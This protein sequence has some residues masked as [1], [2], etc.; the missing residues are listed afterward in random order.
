[1][2]TNPI[3]PKKGICDPH[4]HIFGGKAYLY[5][6]SDRSI[7]NTTW[8]MD[9]WVIWSSEDL[10]HWEFESSFKPEDSYIG[11]CDACWAVD[12]AE[13]NGKY[14]YYFSNKNIDTGVAVSENPGG[15]FRDALGK[16][17][18]PQDLTPSC[19]YDP[20]VFTDD[21]G[22]SYIIWGLPDGDGYYIAK[23]N[24]DM[25]SLAEEPKRILLDGGTARDDK[26]FVH[27]KNGKYYLSWASK[28]A[29][30]ESVYGPY[31]TMGNLRLSD[32]H[33]SFFSFKG[34]DFNAFTIFEPTKYFRSTGLC[35]VHYRKN[36]EMEADPLIAE[37]GV[38]HYDANW[39]NLQAVWFM[40][41]ENAEKTENIWGGF[42]VC[43]IS[44]KTRLYYPNIENIA[45]KKRL[46]FEAASLNETDS[47][48]EV[49]DR[50]AEKM[51]GSCKVTKTMGYD[52]MGYE[53]FFC[54][55]D[56][57]GVGDKLMMELR[58]RGNGSEL[59]RL[60]TLHFYE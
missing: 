49:W 24:E 50:K 14:Y 54:E 8:T 37:Y 20:T 6:S 48:I 29:V 2:K 42:D 43:N 55:L 23:L 15:P 56:L 11:E 3:I 31:T 32:D 18:L 16:P 21:D 28:Y 57:S 5:A 60:K 39:N 51:I 59:M 33:G 41:C 36:G 19:Q 44:E 35:Y 9:D 45:G 46:Y 30:S 1:M 12:A 53:P 17:L 47:V 52:H 58:F 34:Q 7:D 10:I 4:I 40:E 22:I 13:K 25:I 38:G 27:K 26:N